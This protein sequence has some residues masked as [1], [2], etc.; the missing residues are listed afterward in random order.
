LSRLRERKE[1][2][3]QQEKTLVC[4]RR[5]IVKAFGHENFCVD[6]SFAEKFKIKKIHKHNKELEGTNSI[7]ENGRNR[8]GKRFFG[9]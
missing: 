9:A 7:K 1:P 4:G 3:S 6:Q 2:D 5:P 8:L